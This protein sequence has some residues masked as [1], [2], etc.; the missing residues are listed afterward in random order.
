MSEKK[1]SLS[2]QYKRGVEGKR[3]KDRKFYKD[4]DSDQDE[5]TIFYE[6]LDSLKVAKIGDQ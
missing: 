2:K 6:D 4:D 5:E 3:I 1:E